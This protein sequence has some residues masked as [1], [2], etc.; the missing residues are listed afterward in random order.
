VSE[1]EVPVPDLDD[2]IKDL[3]D[4]VP[5]EELLVSE[6]EMKW[7]SDPRRKLLPGDFPRLLLLLSLLDAVD[8][9]RRQRIS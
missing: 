9:R 3:L 5:F 1:L 2:T 7:E 6:R 4:G 8:E